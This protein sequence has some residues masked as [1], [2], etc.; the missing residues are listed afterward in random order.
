MEQK[1]DAEHDFIS[2]PW[3]LAEFG[4]WYGTNQAEA[5]RFYDDAKAFLNSGNYPR[6]KLYEVYDTVSVV[7]DTRTSYTANGVLDPARAGQVQRI[8]QRPDLHRS[9]RRATATSAAPAD[10]GPPRRLRHERGERLVLLLGYLQ[11]TVIPAPPDRRRPHRQRQRRGGEHL[12]RHRGP[13]PQRQAGTG[14]RHP[15]RSHVPRLG[16]GEGEPGRPADHAPAAGA[17]G[18]RHRADD[19]YTSVTWTATDTQ[20]RLVSASYVGKESRQ[21]PHLLGLRIADGHRPVAAGRRLRTDQ[22]ELIRPG[23]GCEGPGGTSSSNPRSS[24]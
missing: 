24:A 9:G 22:R 14:L 10:D 6:L 19:G 2:K 11:R 17:S 16:V 3:G 18:E 15:G 12:G 20:W 21:R 5:Y 13:R 8:R 7:A 1:S 23:Q 4:Y